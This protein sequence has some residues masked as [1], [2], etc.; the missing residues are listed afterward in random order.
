MLLNNLFALGPGL[1]VDERQHCLGN[2]LMGWWH[3]LKPLPYS[4]ALTR[5][6]RMSVGWETVKKS[7][8][9]LNGIYEKNWDILSTEHTWATL[10]SL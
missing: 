3:I 6:L 8:P 7:S 5:T 4:L 1:R 9:P 10:F 2:L